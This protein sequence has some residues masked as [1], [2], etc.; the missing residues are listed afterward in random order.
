MGQGTRAMSA[1]ARIHLRDR[2]NARL[3]PDAAGRI[4][5]TSRANAVTGRVPY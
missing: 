5:F 1:E 4:R 3:P 2:L